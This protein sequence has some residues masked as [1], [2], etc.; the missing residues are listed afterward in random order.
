MLRRGLDLEVDGSRGRGRLKMTWRRQ[1]EE[2][3]EQIGLEKEDATNRTKPNV[4]YELS[5]NLR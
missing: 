2:P 3:I 5:R 4:V 1:V